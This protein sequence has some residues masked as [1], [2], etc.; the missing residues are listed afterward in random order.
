M[1]AKGT[2]IF[3]SALFALIASLFGFA[4][5][6]GFIVTAYLNSMLWL[7]VVGIVFLLVS[8]YSFYSLYGWFTEGVE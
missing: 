4:F 3:S 6:L 5:G 1:V 8:G 7:G 2:V